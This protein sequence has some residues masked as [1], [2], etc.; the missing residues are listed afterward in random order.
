VEAQKGNPFNGSNLFHRRIDVIQGRLRLCDQFSINNRSDLENRFWVASFYEAISAPYFTG[1]ELL[2]SVIFDAKL[3]V[4]QFN[5]YA[6]SRTRLIFMKA[7]FV[8]ANR[9]HL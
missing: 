6:F 2:T 5:G 1:C 3:R 8:N 9:W 4:A 7:A